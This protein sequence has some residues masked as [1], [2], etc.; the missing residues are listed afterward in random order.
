[1]KYFIFIFALIISSSVIAQ[2]GVVG[3]AGRCPVSGNPNLV[4]SLRV[5]DQRQHASEAVDTTSGDVYNYKFSLPIGTRWVK[6]VGVSIT[7]GPTIDLTEN[8][9]N[10][11]GLVVL[12]SL[13]SSHLVQGGVS[14]NDLSPAVKDSIGNLNVSYLSVPGLA[15]DTALIGSLRLPIE[16]NASALY[17]DS[18]FNRDLK[19]PLTPKYP[20]EIGLLTGNE[21]QL[22]NFL[23][24]GNGVTSYKDSSL[25]QNAT[26][27]NIIAG[28]TY[29]LGWSTPKSSWNYDYASGF[30]IWVWFENPSDISISTLT[31]KSGATQWVRDMQFNGFRW[32]N[33]KGLA[34]GWNLVRYQFQE[35][36]TIGMNNITEIRATFIATKATKVRVGCI[37]TEKITKKAQIILG[38]DGAY[39]QGW[40]G[41]R[42]VSGQT[43]GGFD[44]WVVD[45]KHKIVFGLSPARHDAGLNI[46]A[47]WDSIALLRSQQPAKI[48]ISFHSNNVEFTTGISYDSTRVATEKAMRRIWEKGYG[49]PKWRMAVTQ[50]FGPFADEMVGEAFGLYATATG[51]GFAGLN[52]YPHGNRHNIPR[53]SLEGLNV[54][55]A[56]KVFNEMKKF[57]QGCVFYTHMITTANA[58]DSIVNVMLPRW[59]Y[60]LSKVDQGVSEGWLEIIDYETYQNSLLECG[61]NDY[62]F[63]LREALLKACISKTN[64]MSLSSANIPALTILPLS[65]TGSTLN[66][67]KIANG[68]SAGQ[69][70]RWTGANWEAS[71]LGISKWD[72]TSNNGIYRN[73]YVHI[74]EPINATPIGVAQLTIDTTGGKLWALATVGNT[75]IIVGGSSQLGNIASSYNKSTGS[76][77]GVGAKSTISLGANDTR[78]QNNAR[79]GSGYQLVSQATANAPS[80]KS[81]YWHMYNFTFNNNASDYTTLFV[82]LAYPEALKQG[83]FYNGSRA[84]GTG[85]PSYNI[86]GSL[87]SDL[88]NGDV[89]RFKALDASWESVPLPA[90]LPTATAANQILVSNAAGTAYTPTPIATLAQTIN[91]GD[92]VFVSRTIADGATALPAVTGVINAGWYRVPEE[93]DGY[94]LV[95]INYDFLATATTGSN[96][97]LSVNKLS[98]TNNSVNLLNLTVAALSS[99]HRFTASTTPLSKGDLLRASVV[100]AGTAVPLGLVMTYVFAR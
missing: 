75:G 69:S 23:L 89:L 36:D 86:P 90:A 8:N 61:L 88:A 16:N 58:P 28:G 41:N 17:R 42:L 32:N 26:E 38:V 73:S 57:R 72:F 96:Y 60:F 68:T 46:A 22:S 25:F 11:S 31:I 65:G 49:Y 95:S 82:P 19:R 9:G 80:S 94:K 98:L 5:I 21:N 2:E 83:L 52:L 93:L 13:D 29:E 48:E 24:G 15:P 78:D 79:S 18:I 47:T 50:N 34:K 37:F 12:S 67:I 59:Q 97:E 84:V 10:V 56:D 55:Q 6:Q 44:D 62:D 92:T 3:G 20:N 39:T 14:Y 51:R 64:K 30:G 77:G 40:Y 99:P 27:I 54:N 71:T 85:E 33:D 81:G 74:G 100:T 43:Q 53:I 63:V 87:T 1:M 45:R 66:P 7:D 91:A 4:L 35:S 76:F 70:L